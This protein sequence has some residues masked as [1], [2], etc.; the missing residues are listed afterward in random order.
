VLRRRAGGYT[1]TLQ[2]SAPLRAGVPVL[3]T[4]TIER[5]GRLI[6]DMGQY[7]GTNGHM[8]AV[9]ANLRD[10]VHTHT[11]AA[12]GAVTAAMATS[13]GPRFTFAL[14]PRAAGLTKIWAQFQRGGQVITVPFTFWVAPVAKGK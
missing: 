3:M 1:V 9:N 4:Y 7:L 13:H 11:V 8:M 14:T 10:A 12:G 2:P 6:T 5:N